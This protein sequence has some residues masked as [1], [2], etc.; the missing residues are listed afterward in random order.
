M[1]T[2]AYADVVKLWRHTDEPEVTHVRMWGDPGA[3]PECGGDG[4][5]D[6]VDLIDRIAYQHC[7]DCR[8]KWSERETDAS[9]LSNE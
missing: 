5:L 1:R 4:F 3:C 7:V 6:H 2:R 9:L 8:H